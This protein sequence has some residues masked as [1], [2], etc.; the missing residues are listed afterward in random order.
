MTT[1]EAA[2]PPRKLVRRLNLF[3]ATMIVMGG[4]IGAG[5]F[6]N[7]AEVARHVEAPALVVGAWL[8][9]GAIAMVGALVYA[10]LAAR[11]PE[12]GGQ[13]AYLRDA[14]GPLPAFLYGWSLLLVIQS[15]GMAAVAITFARYANI[16]TGLTLPDGLVASAALALLTAIN[17]LGVRTGSNVQSLLMLLKIGAIALLVLAGWLIAPAFA[18][19]ASPAA[20]PAAGGGGAI[21]LFAAL[22]PVMFAYGG[23]QTSSFIAGEMR[24][25]ERDLSR[26]LLL[27]VAGVVLLY[28]AVAFVCVR[29]LG[30]AGL[31]SSETPASAVMR[32]A[33]GEHGATLIALGIAIS[34]LGFLSQGMLTT[35]RVYFAMAEDRLFFR[36]VGQVSPR[37]HAPIFAILLQGA[38]AIAIAL[39]GTYGQIL[40]Y[41]VS[42]DFLWFGLTGA[43]LFVF[44]HRR[45]SS[46]GFRVPLH[47]L[48]T[49]LFVAACFLIVVATVWHAPANSA[50]GFLILLAGV[51]VCLMWLRRRQRDGQA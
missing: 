10:E 46:G 34:A 11:R 30:V 28:A 7:P 14:W 5:I 1:D 41:V 36:R 2:S 8:I 18:A 27:G 15:G 51:P 50:V 38:A 29:V 9:G 47:P 13:Y 42:V 45:P 35:P 24:D 17:C 12:T 6:V 16:L 37:T 21:G 4:I 44:R 19:P 39:S 20:A 33:L 31:A 40:A 43:A 22:T 49:G 26:G 23:W 48:S 25:P 32:A 3:D